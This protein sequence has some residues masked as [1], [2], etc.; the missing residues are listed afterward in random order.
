MKS[1]YKNALLI[2][3]IALAAFI[4]CKDTI[5]ADVYENPDADCKIM[6]TGVS[7][8]FKNA[9]LED[10]V[11]KYSETC[12]IEIVEFS[13][14]HKID[15]DDYAAIILMDEVEGWMIL[16]RRARRLI[17]KVEPREKL[18]PFLTAGDEEYEYEKNGIDAITS[19]SEMDKVEESVATISERIDAL[20]Q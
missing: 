11:E 18:I 20:I 7:S 13:K 15:P 16:N 3:I 2:V 17:R 6:I 12:Q 4:S 19:A 1:H 10:I 9:V 8:E 5:P 14:A